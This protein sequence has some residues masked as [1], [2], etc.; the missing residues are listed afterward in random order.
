M[1]VN[2]VRGLYHHHKITPLECATLLRSP[3]YHTEVTERERTVLDRSKMKVKPVEVVTMKTAKEIMLESLKAHD[4]EDDI[5]DIDPPPIVG[6]PVPCDTLAIAQQEFDTTNRFGPKI[7]INRRHRLQRHIKHKGTDE[8]TNT[9][10][11]YCK[12][13]WWVQVYTSSG[14][15]APEDVPTSKR[16]IESEICKP[17]ETPFKAVD[18]RMLE[19]LEVCG[20]EDDD[21]KLDPIIE[22]KRI[23]TPPPDEPLDAVYGMKMTRL[24]KQQDNEIRS[25]CKKYGSV[26]ILN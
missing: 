6:A 8:I 1:Q 15:R 7:G 25:M 17:V 9:L 20:N 19:Y 5:M 11:K 22:C 21:M 26:N 4:E 13:D 3:M 18:Q 16:V 2:W 24:T 12:E 23:Y 14:T 10:L